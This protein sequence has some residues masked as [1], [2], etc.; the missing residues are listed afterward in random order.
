MTTTTDSATQTGAT[1]ESKQTE[2]Q[3]A[4]QKADEAKAKE[5]QDKADK[6][7]QERTEAEMR[8]R[9]QD[10]RNSMI[11]EI[12]AKHR[13]SVAKDMTDPP[14]D[15]FDKTQEEL[16]DDAAEVERK[17]L[18]DVA[19]EAERKAQIE[20]QTQAPTVLKAEDLAKFKVTQVIDGE[21]REV[22]LEE[23]M[24]QHQ[25]AGAADYRLAK[26]TETLDSAMKLAKEIEEQSRGKPAKKKDDASDDEKKTTEVDVEGRVKDAI[27]KMLDNDTEGAAKIFTETI[28]A[29][30]GR[31]ATPDTE[32]IVSQAVVRIQMQQQLTSFQTD[33]KDI[34]N[35]KYFGR[36]VDQEFAEL[37]PRDAKGEFM[38]VPPGEF[39]KALR[40][41][42]DKVRDWAKKIGGEKKPA[43]D[44]TKKAADT[45]AERELRKNDLDQTTGAS[46]KSTSSATSAEPSTPQARSNVIAEIAKARGQQL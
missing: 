16:D 10:P 40:T 44:A 46:T 3:I 20:K 15:D 31:S 33:Y 32:E 28:A 6:E 45:R 34:V 12:A 4:A 27:E 23:V 37:I 38:P 11:D 24:R 18:E 2:Q 17:R 36:M 9:A 8:K 22:S 5:A 29:V 19:A 35:D 14:V 41:A 42:G 13:E 26:A 30:R 39:G 43:E 7:A 21:S 25:K 1:D